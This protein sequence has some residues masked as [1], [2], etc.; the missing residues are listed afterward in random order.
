[1]IA[2]TKIFTLPLTALALAAA[3][4]FSPAAAA[5]PKCGNVSSQTTHCTTAGGSHQ[6]VTTPP[7][8]GAPTWPG[9]TYRYWDFPNYVI[10]F[11]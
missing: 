3:V 11:P 1:M 7:A 6:I 10:E 8:M 5:A 4:L 9:F 2:S